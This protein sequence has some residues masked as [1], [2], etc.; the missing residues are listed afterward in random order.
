VFTWIGNAAAA[1]CGKHGDITHQAQT[2]GCSRQTVFGPDGQ[3][4]DRPWAEEERRQASAQLQAPA[5]AKVRRQLADE[6]TLTFLDRLHEDLAAAEAC[7]ERRAALVALWRWRRENHRRGEAK[8]GSASAAEEMRIGGVKARLREDWQRSSK[9]VSRVL[10][11]VLRAQRGGVRQQRGAHASV[12][13]PPSQ[14]GV[15]RPQAPVLQL[16][17]FSGRQTPTPLS[18][19]T[20]APEVA[21]LRSL[22]LAP[23][24]PR[25][26]GETTVKFSTCSLRRCHKIVTLL[27]DFGAG[28]SLTVREVFYTLEKRYSNASYKLIP[29]AINLREHWGQ[30]S[31]PE[32][33]TRHA[34]ALAFRWPNEL[35]SIWNA[36]VAIAILDGFDELA[37][38]SIVATRRT[39]RAARQGATQV[40][41]EFV[42]QARGRMGLLLTGRGHY[43]DSPD[44]LRDCCGLLESDPIYRLEPF[45]ETETVTYL[46]RKGLETGLPDWL[47]RTPL[48]LGYLASGHL[49]EEVAG[50]P[51]RESSAR[52]R[53]GFLC[54]RV[55]AKGW[56]GGPRE[57]G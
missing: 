14:P 13:A 11:R 47:P 38:Q 24:R 3:L 4:N 30:T 39:R 49:L 26:V 42:A 34:T 51:R 44:E 57:G 18:L 20:L 19:P 33:L 32:V 55:W 41:R 22:D 9:R 8:S 35:V 45:G 43:F 53:P 27:G 50:L 6:R 52:E 31:I 10:F 5:W 28:K 23:D 25:R 56:N 54:F 37:S 16:P 17:A 1:L 46:Q 29:L 36:D 15:A 21:L 7:P 48:L 40:V 12:K 2:A